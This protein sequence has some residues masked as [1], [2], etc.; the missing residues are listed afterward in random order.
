M[1]KQTE[2]LKTSINKT[3]I[4]NNYED[5]YNN[6]NNNIDF[7][8][9][10]TNLNT[11]EVNISN[12]SDI[13]NINSIYLDEKQKKK[14][15]YIFP[16]EYNLVELMEESE[17]INKLKKDTEKKLFSIKSKLK[18]K[19]FDLN[20]AIEEFENLQNCYKIYEVEHGELRKENIIMEKRNKFLMK[21]L[22]DHEIFI[23]KFDSE[24]KIIKNRIELNKTIFEKLEK[25]MLLKLYFVR[26]SNSMVRSLFNIINIRR[27]HIEM[28]KIFSKRD[29][30]S[31][32]SLFKKL[33]DTEGKII[34]EYNKFFE[35]IKIEENKID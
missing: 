26:F 4:E 1:Y 8:N 32:V 34:N 19:N 33:D 12:L 9:F 22:E 16:A 20:F 7:M 17:K 25:D 13:S 27:L 14:S 30:E 11:K 18:T 21:F 5:D 23:K 6:E 15:N 10:G 3:K 24:M 2:I 29:M 31:Y 35:F 28:L